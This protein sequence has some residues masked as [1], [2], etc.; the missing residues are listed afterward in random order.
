MHQGTW[1]GCSGYRQGFF[2]HSACTELKVTPD[3]LADKIVRC[4][5]CHCWK[6]ISC[7]PY[8]QRS[9][10]SHKHEDLMIPRG[11][12]QVLWC[13]GSEILS[14]TEW[15]TLGPLSGYM[16]HTGCV[17]N[18]C[19]LVDSLR[20]LKK[21]QLGLESNDICS[22]ELSLCNWHREREGEKKS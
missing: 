17:H 20:H 5:H 13:C 11:P 16:S 8:Q 1:A 14:V 4:V 22:S 12:F 19:C 3:L 7:S 21:Y 2:C 15:S 9:A 10:S 18:P 6:D